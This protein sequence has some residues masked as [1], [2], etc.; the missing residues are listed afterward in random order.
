MCDERH[1]TMIV[2][3]IFGWIWQWYVNR[4]ADANV[5]LNR[6]PGVR[7]PEDH[8]PLSATASCVVLS[9]LSQLIVVP[10]EIVNG[11]WPNA[12][13][14]CVDAPV[15]IFTVVLPAGAGVGPVDGAE[16]EL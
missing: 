7:F 13:V 9:V 8:A 1:C 4:P 11:F 14:V 15:G 2:P 3:T 12:A 5:K 16:G 10:T 6:P